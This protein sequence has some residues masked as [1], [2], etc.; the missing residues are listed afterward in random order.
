MDHPVYLP[1]NTGLFP[2]AHYLEY[3]SIIFLDFIFFFLLLFFFF[4][5]TQSYIMLIYILEHSDSF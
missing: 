4:F 1:A 2:V 3:L 5:L